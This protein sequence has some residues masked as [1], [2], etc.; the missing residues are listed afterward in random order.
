[1][2]HVPLFL[3]KQ[4]PAICCTIS[5]LI[6]IAFYLPA[7]AQ[8]GAGTGNSQWQVHAPGGETLCADGYEF[9]YFTA[10][11]IPANYWFTLPVRERAGPGNS[12]I[13]KQIRLPTVIT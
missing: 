11:P 4:L 1:M 6:G 2:S 5:L 7:F 13:L 9:K 3:R 12:V 8:N 10:R